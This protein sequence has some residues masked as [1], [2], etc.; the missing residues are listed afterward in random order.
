MNMPE[1]SRRCLACGASVR[2]GSRFCPQCG[3]EM[4]QEREA[5]EANHAAREVVADDAALTPDVA[6]EK[7][8]S[9][10]ASSLTKTAG[11]ASETEA[12]HK[13]EEAAYKTEA[14]DET[15]DSI[16]PPLSSRA[17]GGNFGDTP[18]LGGGDMR[19]AS[20]SEAASLIDA[21]SGEP[22]PARA[23]S[24]RM[25]APQRTE[26][27]ATTAAA[28][29]TNTPVKGRRRTV[30]VVEEGLR[31]RVE[32]WRDV[33]VGMLDDASEDSGLRFVIIALAMFLI[34]LL[35]LFISNFL[36]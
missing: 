9:R 26:Q 15:P 27:T 29:T 6:A 19:R 20:T 34:F 2:A 7:F 24:S 17:R 25:P 18:G 14:A 1:I 5:H 8:S 28:T 21:A 33:S 4:R 13:I 3:T 22:E 36:K 10:E 16:A 31:P 11:E 32:K 12:A 23:D 30:A 35:F